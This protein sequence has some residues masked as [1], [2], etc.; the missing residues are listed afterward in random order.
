MLRFASGQHHQAISLV[1]KARQGAYNYGGE[2][3]CATLPNFLKVSVRL[4][5]AGRS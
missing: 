4:S 5:G 3:P 1:L 2:T